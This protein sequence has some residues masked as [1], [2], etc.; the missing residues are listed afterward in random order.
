MFNNKIVSG[1]NFK[2]T[3][4]VVYPVDPTNL[5]HEQFLV[6]LSWYRILKITTNYGY[7]NNYPLIHKFYSNSII[8]QSC[9]ILFEAIAS[10][11]VTV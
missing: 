3:D 2:A 4:S 7:S 6:I 8:F 5:N 10:L 9:K 1:K 11:I